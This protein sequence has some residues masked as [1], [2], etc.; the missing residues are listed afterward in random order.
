MNVKRRENK[1]AYLQLKKKLY[2]RLIGIV[3]VA[4]LLIAAFYL[5]IWHRRGGDWAVAFMQR[6]LKLRPEQAYAVYQ[7]GFRNF[8]GIIWLAAVTLV[9]AVLLR[10]ILRW[11]SHYFYT[12]NQGIDA[13]LSQEQEILLPPEMSAIQGKLNAVKAELTRRAMAAELANQ[14][15]NELVMY[16]AHDIRTP[17]TSVIGYLSL[18]A[19]APEMPLKQ[20]ARYTHIAL[21]KANRLEK[22]LQEF[23]EI[24]HYHLQTLSIE[25]QTIDL[26]TML[27]QIADEFSP[28]LAQ[29]G[30]TVTLRADE[31]IAVS[32]DPDRLAR[33]FHN[34]LK[35]AAG[36]SFPNTEIVIAA[37]QEDGETVV[38]F[39][40]QGETIPKEKLPRLF[41]KFYRADE[42][43]AT[44]SGGTGLGLAIAKEI[45]TL[46]G[47]RICAESQQ[48]VTTFTVRLPSPSGEE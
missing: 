37:A 5:L 45:V 24:T 35:N 28:I 38:S 14:R 6:V 15:K 2:V 30:N 9:F 17:L 32:G 19:E 36:Y 7:Y 29:T 12:V 23:F 4:F 27:M 31:S 48:G 10:T 47:G 43:R 42:A 11:F 13:L 1:F 26:Y 22:M 20:R 3:I 41:E 44:Q 33:V 39:T 46:H 8:S 21:S 34:I 40:N 18:M 16:L 25:K